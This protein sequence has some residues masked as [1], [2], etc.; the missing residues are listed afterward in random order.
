M[1][2]NSIYTV[3]KYL[4]LALL[5]S[6][7]FACGDDGEAE[8]TFLNFTAKSEISAEGGD[9]FDAVVDQGGRGDF[10][11]VQ[12]AINAVPGDSKNHL[13]GESRDKVKIQFALNRVEASSN[14]MT[15][16]YS[17]FN[18]RINATDIYMENISI[19]NL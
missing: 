4:L 12:A 13:I 10:T 6:T 8:D 1:N 11:T 19:I 3:G 5:I 7:G 18:E 16:P 9:V 14:T 2:A 17:I 15:W